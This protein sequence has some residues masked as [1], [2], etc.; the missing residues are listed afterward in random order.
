[1]FSFN[2]GGTVI[3]DASKFGYK[4][5]FLCEIMLCNIL[6]FNLTDIR[7]SRDKVNS[8]MKIKY[9]IVAWTALTGHQSNYWKTSRELLNVIHICNFCNIHERPPHLE[10]DDNT[11][12]F[13]SKVH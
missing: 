1:M 2:E 3:I 12:C 9:A 5:D 7:L 4:N 6:G 10:C 13:L 8:K 11:L